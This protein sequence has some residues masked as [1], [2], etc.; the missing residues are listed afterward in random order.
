V[1]ASLALVCVSAD[2]FRPIGIPDALRQALVPWAP[3]VDQPGE[4]ERSA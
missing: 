3:A 4:V 1:K 2:R